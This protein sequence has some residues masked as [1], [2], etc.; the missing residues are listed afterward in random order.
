MRQYY[1]NIAPV[2]PD[3]VIY[4]PDFGY[5]D[6]MLQRKEAQYNKGFAQV[7]KMW[8]YISRPVT[9]EQNAGLRDAFLKQAKENLKNL[10][11]LDLSEY[12]NVES[13]L[14]VFAPYYKNTNL[15]MDQEL[16]QFYD[17][18]ESLANT[19]R[20]QEGGKYFNEINLADVRSQ[21]EDFAKAK[22]ED[23]KYF[24][25]NKRPYTPYYNTTDERLKA[26]QNFKPSSVTTINK[27]GFYITT[28]TDKSWYK[29]DISKYLEGTLSPQAKQQFSIE[30]RQAFR[31][32]PDALI[33]AYVKQSESRLPAIEKELKEID[34]RMLKAKTPEETQQ[35]Q[36]NKDYFKTLRNSISENVTNL[37]KGDK[38]FINQKFEE[39]AKSVYIDAIVDQTADSFAH[40]HVDQKL[41]FDQAALTIYR[42]DQANYR[43]KLN[44]E[45]A[46]ERLKMQ[47]RA[48]KN[49][50]EDDV[51]SPI[52]VSGGADEETEE[53]SVDDLKKKIGQSE[54]DVD[55]ARRQLLAQIV[56]ADSK[57][58][59][60]S[61]ND[62]D[63]YT[64]A[65]FVSDPNNAN[66]KYVKDYVQ[67]AVNRNTYKNAYEN[68]NEDI[69]RYVKEQMGETN[70]N[71]FKKA[72]SLASSMSSQ[73][74]IQKLPYSA[75]TH[76]GEDG[77]M[78]PIKQDRGW[79]NSGESPY[80]NAPSFQ[81]RG[82]I[83]SN[84]YGIF[85]QRNLTQ[86]QSKNISEEIAANRTGVGAA[87]YR[88]L[89]SAY[90]TY[91]QAA[92]KNQ[93]TTKISLVDKGLRTTKGT[94][95]FKAQAPQAAG[96]IGENT[97]DISYITTRP[98][99]DGKID[100]EIATKDMGTDKWGEDRYKNLIEK[101]R[102]EQ[103]GATVSEYNEKKPYITIR[104]LSTNTPGLS[105]FDEYNV[106]SK[107]APEH[108][109]AV[110]VLANWRGPSVGASY[111][112]AFVVSDATNKNRIFYIRKVTGVDEGSDTYMLLNP[113]SGKPMSNNIN[114]E[115]VVPQ[116]NFMKELVYGK[117]SPYL[118]EVL[119]K[120]K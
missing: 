26:M 73:D 82:D 4:N 17:Q 111:D 84:Q 9:N 98:R 110:R 32:N 113:M 94:S 53:L 38:A 114:S 115:T 46:M 72:Q 34:I 80:I 74:Q 101:I 23:W 116:Y 64:F 2:F 55:T 16:T 79:Y 104:G 50:E 37:K 119:L 5:F 21:R 45:A 63:D 22:P 67:A 66:N 10:S 6:K 68:R 109:G 19:Y 25:N 75:F 43:A 44:N 58:K 81:N 39:L 35:L 65:K 69:E 51:V 52:T 20:N 120:L 92:I 60:I 95:G 76:R 56:N 90:N 18:Q 1:S 42:E 85:K 83:Q 102:A 96:L 31:N 14:N 11:T 36:A 24:Y 77:K 87:R 7:S 54:T 99:V 15:I 108:T 118:D 59:I 71:E 61:I 117:Y 103:P 62:V 49:G 100:M 30:A 97:D 40:K 112:Q 29:E 8:D 41:E 48:K 3:P 28:I 78:T 13:A 47:L 105:S 89:E 33:G 70:Y 106:Y 107:V 91:R 27:N 93:V 88:D 86:G 12:Q 57:D